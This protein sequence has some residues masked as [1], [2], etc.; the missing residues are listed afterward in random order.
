ML[1]VLFVS[2]L[3]MFFPQETVPVPTDVTIWGGLSLALIFRVVIVPALLALG[4]LKDSNKK[5]VGGVLIALGV[6]AA[7]AYSV[8]TAKVSD[9]LMLLTNLAAGGF[10]GIGAVGLHSTQKNL[11]EWLK[12]RKAK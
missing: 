12:E 5:T 6:L 1:T 7:G 9:P 2:W 10:A 4:L 11:T 3:F 8:F